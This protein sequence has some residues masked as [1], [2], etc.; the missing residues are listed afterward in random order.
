MTA[1]TSFTR[2]IQ[3]G[4]EFVRD[5]FKPYQGT[6]VK[7]KCQVSQYQK[8]VNHQVSHQAP[9]FVHSNSTLF[10]KIIP[11]VYYQSLASELR[12]Q[13]AQRSW[14][15]GSSP[16][17]A[18]AGLAVLSSFKKEEDIVMDQ[19]REMGKTSQESK[20]NFQLGQFPCLSLDS[21]QLGKMIGKGC[22]AVV[23]EASLK[24]QS[25]PASEE[26][27][28]KK[29]SEGDSDIVMI[30][31]LESDKSDPESRSDTDGDSDIIML[32]QSESDTESIDIISDKSDPEP[33]GETD[34][35]IDIIM[36]GESESDTDSIEI[37]SDKPDPEFKGDSIV[38]DQSVSAPVKFT[39]VDV[40]DLT[41]FRTSLSSETVA[42]NDH[43]HDLNLSLVQNSFVIL[44]QS[45]KG[46]NAVHFEHETAPPEYNLAIKIMYN[47]QTE[48]K[49]SAILREMEKEM[50]PANLA[51]TQAQMKEWENGNKVKKKSLPQHPN[52]VSMWGV[53]V[54]PFPQLP[55]GK[56][57]YPAAL[58]KRLNP[59]GIGR[60]QTLFL[61]MKKYDMNLHQYLQTRQ[62]DVRTRILLLAQLLE[63][64]VHMGK[65]GIAHRDMKNDNI[66]LDCSTGEVPQLVI[67]DF[68]CC[69]ADSQNG[70]KL[71]Y[72]SEEVDRG[73]NSALMAPE[74]S[75]AIPGPNHY[76]DYSKSDLW[77]VGALSY[78]ILGQDNPFYSREGRKNL[79]SRTYI[80][81]DLPLLPDSI[82]LEVRKLVSSLLQRDPG[83]RPTPEVAADA[84]SLYL[85]APSH[86][87]LPGNKV[88]SQD[89]RWWL[90]I[91]AA[92][93]SI[94]RLNQSEFTAEFYLKASFLSHFCMENMQAAIVLM[95][96]MG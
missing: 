15:R 8:D 48:S 65:Y 11:R 81:S 43:L 56:E 28:I 32:D 40:L 61:V 6:K 90:A 72:A 30:D 17:F 26:N 4:K 63:G 94:L 67:G 91:L 27:V 84:L 66:L 12:R 44:S 58:P 41:E 74:I 57:H 19:I 25:T 88:S 64:V 79:D 51:A 21:F 49:T 42:A 70:L 47:Y 96:M 62:P 38:P 14:G 9:Q 36:I 53:F 68:G 45:D 5:I 3:A 52:I 78:E 46:E 29:T 33:K 60:N 7:T 18:F 10:S 39:E 31:Q 13:A 69:L 95:Q 92:E 87:W 71:P 89:V 35:D 82:P 34:S 23:Y 73:G 93:V 76:L 55:E 54:D 86:W 2:L 20:S 59:D 24:V 16:L 80:E 77:S 85:W 50:V 22:Y 37:I 75:N 1:R 83:K